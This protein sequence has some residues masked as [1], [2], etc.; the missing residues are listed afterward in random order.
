MNTDGNKVM[1]RS[2]VTLKGDNF[3]AFVEGLFRRHNINLAFLTIAL[4]GKLAYIPN[5]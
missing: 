2:N 1:E 3:I 5:T 4:I